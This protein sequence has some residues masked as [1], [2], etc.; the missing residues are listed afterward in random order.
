MYCFIDTKA[1][2]F[3]GMTESVTLSAE[4]YLPDIRKDFIVA[5]PVCVRLGKVFCVRAVEGVLSFTAEA[6]SIMRN[7][8]LSVSA[9]YVRCR[10]QVRHVHCTISERAKSAVRC[11]VPRFLRI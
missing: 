4:G 6:E 3:C 11:C 8:Y 9:L 10:R 2:K 5:A 1:E 7:L